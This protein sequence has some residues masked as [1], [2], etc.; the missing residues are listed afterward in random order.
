MNIKSGTINKHAL[1]SRP[2]LVSN[3]LME[4]VA[5]L[6]GIKENTVKIKWRRYLA[7]NKHI[8]TRRNGKSILTMENYKDFIKFVQDEILSRK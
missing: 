2:S 7:N 8:H 5:T 6:W 3:F 1:E 4:F